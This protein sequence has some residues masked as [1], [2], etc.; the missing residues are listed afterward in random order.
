MK[1]IIHA[2]FILVIAMQ[3]QGQRFTISG[4]VEDMATGEKLIG[5]SV[6]DSNSGL[7]TIANEYGFYSLT[8]PSDEVS[9]AVSYVGYTTYF[10]EFTL[11]R[12]YE[13]D[14][15]LDPSLEIEEVTITTGRPQDV[16][17]SSQM[18][19]IKLSPK[20]I[21]AMPSFLGESDVLKALQLMPGVQSGTEGSSVM[22]VR[23]EAPTRT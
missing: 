10:E 7:G 9:L 2:L 13:L 11:D 23:G 17:R 3:A 5:A 14:I 15:Q 21:K 19:S 1:R 18:S 12:N 20:Q 4:Y 8:L 22:Y 6:Y 16:V